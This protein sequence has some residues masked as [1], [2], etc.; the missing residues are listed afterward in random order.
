VSLRQATEKKKSAASQGL[1]YKAWPRPVFFQSSR[2]KCQRLGQPLLKFSEL[3]SV[4]R[5][6]LPKFNVQPRLCF[7]KPLRILVVEDEPLVAMNLIEMVSEFV[8][9][10]VVVEPSVAAS[11]DALSQAVDFAFL[12]VQ[13]TNGKTF[14]VAHMLERKRVPFVFVSGSPQ[15]QLPSDLRTV[16]FVSKPV[17]PAQIERVLQAL[18]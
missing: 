16:P 9:A 7:M 13:V 5:F 3:F 1:P 4:V 14:E 18:P 12:D 10:T 11:K 2:S 8:T 15:D 6:D 17:S